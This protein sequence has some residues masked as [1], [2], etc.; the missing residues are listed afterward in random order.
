[1]KKLIPIM[2]LVVFCSGC[3]MIAKSSLPT[4]L[5]SNEQQWTIEKGQEFTAIQ[6]P[7]FKT[8]TKFI[9]D[10]DLAVLYKGNLLE[11]EQEANR[12]AINA[13][14]AGK[15]TGALLG[16]LGTILTAIAGILAKKGIGNMFQGKK[17]K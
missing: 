6:K 10:E 2:L 4:I 5:V 13:A 14:R 1:M 17:K 16:G 8:P 12:R 3:A 11:L 15:K 7:K 9:A